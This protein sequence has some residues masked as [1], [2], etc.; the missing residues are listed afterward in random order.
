M[1][2]ESKAMIDIIDSNTNLPQVVFPI[3][4]NLNT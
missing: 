4:Q 1:L 2:R 3:N